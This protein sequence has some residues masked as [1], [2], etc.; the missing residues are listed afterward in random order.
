MAHPFL[1][2]T[3]EML[4]KL[5]R[6]NQE[7]ISTAKISEPRFVLAIPKTKSTEELNSQHSET[8][9]PQL[10]P[11]ITV[12]SPNPSILLIRQSGSRPSACMDTHPISVV[13]ENI[14]H[15]AV[16]GASPGI[17]IRYSCYKI[18]H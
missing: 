1:P 3:N 17:Q 18:Q 10:S 7:S 6:I 14:M 2:M 11:L 4:K 13:R 5:T 8:N 16:K 9:H 12:L 15:Q